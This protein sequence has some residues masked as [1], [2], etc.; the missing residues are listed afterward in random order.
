LTFVSVEARNHC[1][2][3]HSSR[4]F[5]EFDLPLNIQKVFDEAQHLGAHE[6]GCTDFASGRFLGL[7]SDKLN[8]LHA[9]IE[10]ISDSDTH[11]IFKVLRN[12]GKALPFLGDVDIKDLVDLSAAQHS[13][14]SGGMFF[15]Q[16]S[17]YLSAHSIH[18]KILY[19]LVRENMAD[20]NT[21]LYSAALTGIAMAGQPHE[22]I[23]LALN[24]ANSDCIDLSATAL[25]MLGRMSYHWDKEPNLKNRAQETLKAMVHHSD[26]NISLQALKALSNAAASQPEL[27]SELLAHAQLNNQTAVQV[28]CDF[29]YMNFEVIK[30]HPSLTEILHA[31]TDLSIEYTHDFDYVLSQ[32]IKDGTHDQQI[33]DCLTIWML[34]HPT[35]RIENENLI[36]CFNQS[37]MELINK[38]LVSEYITRWLVSDERA[39]GSAFSDLIGHLWVHGEHAKPGE[40]VKPIL[41][42]IF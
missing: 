38:S 36:S 26:S 39:L 31:L 23:E 9:G 16:V 3:V 12:I 5:D 8:I 42:L 18:T 20:A 40:A 34:K 22:A 10:I 1:T 15:N 37:L 28:L 19:A 27:V 4:K 7:M 30:D 35:N 32:L 14:T 17:E 11:T 41:S 21:N 25:L 6:M 2:A 24:D 33:Y 29:I 13:K